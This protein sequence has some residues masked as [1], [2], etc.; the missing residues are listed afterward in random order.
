[1]KKSTLIEII[2]IIILLGILIFLG[3]KIS[4]LSVPSVS[5]K[6]IQDEIKTKPSQGEKNSSTQ[7]N[8]STGV[9]TISDEQTISG[10]SYTSTNSSEN[11]LLIEDGG[12][13]TLSDI[14]VTKSGDSSDENSDFYGTNAGILVNDDGSLTLT[15]SSIDTSGS[16]ANGLFVYGSGEAVI[17]NTKITTSKNNSGG[18]MVAG[19]GTLTA[20]NVTAITEGNSSAA[21]RSDRGGGTMTVYGGSYTT[22]GV[23]SPAI[24]STADITVN[25]AELSSTKSEGAV[26][27][28][29]NS[30]TLNNVT[31][32]DDN[33][34]L[35]GNSETYKNIFLYQSMSGDADV[36]MATFTA[37]D[38]T[39]TTNNG[40][41][42]F[43]TNTKATINLENNIII[44]NSGDF[45][46]IQTGKW[47][48]SG[49]NGGTVT[50]NAINQEIKGDIIVDNISTLDFSLNSGSYYEGTINSENTAQNIILK[51]DSNSKIK[52][53]GDS[54]ITELIDEDSSYS[55]I[56][57][58]GY[59]LYVNGSAI[60]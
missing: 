21:I 1:M 19:G 60:N 43:V 46:R 25:N 15:D 40:D 9:V 13:A 41:T 24:Y 45:L 53:T 34:T 39:I 59:K 33:T 20:T 52:L 3:I 6:L 26:V 48:K 55:N 16:H 50:L 22:N 28:G 27:E 35:N 42:I 57:F 44:N 29:A 30:I 23:G 7:K 11:A 37:K 31:L 49:S 54:Y 36:G 8:D 56:D 12:E 51:L 2:V 17:S 38:S 18:I 10:E 14:I 58:N 32:T 4:D 5:E 47:G